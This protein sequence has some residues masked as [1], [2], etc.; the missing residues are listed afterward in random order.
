MHEA[1]LAIYSSKPGCNGFVHS[2]DLLQF[3]IMVVLAQCAALLLLQSFEKAFMNIFEN[4]KTH[5]NFS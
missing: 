1:I 3:N 2:N 5:Q 4:S